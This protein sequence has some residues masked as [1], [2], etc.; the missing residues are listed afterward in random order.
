MKNIKKI[1]L[2]ALAIA[3]SKTVF[4]QDFAKTRQLNLNES[5]SNY[6]KI[7]GLFQ[8]W[9]RS[10]D[11][12]P[13]SQV[14]GYD[15]TAGTD[16]GI[17]RYRVQLYSQLTDKV[18]FYSQFGENNVN[19][20]SDRKTGF[21]V[22]DA[23]G[24]YDI[25]KHISVGTGLSGW[26]GLSRFSSPS[27]G[28]I[29]GIDAPL[30]LQTT[31]DVTD[32]FLRK[33]SIFAKGKFGKLDY[34]IALAQPMSIQKAAGYTASP[35]TTT[36]AF[37]PEPPKMQ[38]NAYV[39]YQFKDQEG[40]LTPYTTGTYLG[41]KKVF[42]IGTGL[43]YQKDAMWLLDSA[44][45]TTHHAMF[46]VAGDVYY[47]APVGKKG[48]AISLYGNFTHYDFGHNYLRNSGVMNPATSTT[49]TNTLMNAAG[50]AF[51][52]YGTGNVLY[53][54]AGY[55][56]KDNLI[57]KTTLMPYV[58]L[59][60]ANYERLNNAMNFYDVGVNWLL[61]GHNSKFTLSYQNR[62]VYDT[63]ADLTTRKGAFVAQYQVFIN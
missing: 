58:S 62:P 45:N 14:L 2:L 57:G 43:I 21:F 23:Y 10:M 11:Y 13:G 8:G 44:G 32:Q 31:N 36:A 1:G 26:S 7:T 40:N 12:N 48:E 15:K 28:S 22:H 17:R 37:S 46:H 39:M 38:T 52:M 53:A 30:F 27:V 33:F 47:D 60:H 42:N 20:I 16:L 49:S 56:F 18:F 41:K 54:Q 24:Q 19:S 35:P 4:A 61:A 59:Q 9:V 63:A 51:P 6:I 50:N 55:K 3:S 5:G 34:R 29:L 25:N